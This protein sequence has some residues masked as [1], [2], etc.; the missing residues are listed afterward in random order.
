MRSRLADRFR[1]RRLTDAAAVAFRAAAIAITTVAALPFVP[2]TAADAAAAK[3]PKAAAERA[4][5]AASEAA[6]ATTLRRVAIRDGKAEVANQT[7]VVAQG[8][9]VELQWRSD[10][11]IA[12]HL[13][14][15]DI[16]TKVT[17]PATAV[18]AFT[19]RLAGRFPVT[20]HRQD[21]TTPSRGGLP[22]SP[23]LAR[24]SAPASLRPRPIHASRRP[25]RVAVLRV[26]AAGLALVAS[27]VQ[28]HG[29]GQRFDLPL[30]LWLW[31]G[32]AAATILITFVLVAVFAR[33]PAAPRRP[34]QI[35]LLAVDTVRVA[36]HPAAVALR[37]ATALLFVLVLAAGFLGTQDAYAN[38][39]VVT[40]WVVWWVGF[41]FVCALV[42]DLWEVVDPLRSIYLVGARA[43]GR[44]IG[45]T[46]LSLGRSYPTLLG[47][48]P[49]V[50]LF[51]GF[52]W[53]ELIWTSKDVPRALAGAALGYAVLGWLGMFVFGVETW[54]R[55]GDAFAI[56][57]RVLARF[58]PL[59]L[60]ST[61]PGA[62]R[63]VVL[64]PYGGGL[65]DGV[66]VAWSMVVFV[67][68]MLAT[69]TFDGFHQTPAM[70]Q[71]ETAAQTSR[72][73]AMLLFDLSQSGI[74]ETQAVH[75]AT[76]LA[77]PLAFVAAFAAT[78]AAMVVLAAR[79][80]QRV[81]ASPRIDAVGVR[82]AAGWFVMTL[83]PIAVAYHLAHYASLLL[84]AGQFVV[85]LASD[86]FGFGWDLFGTRSRAVDL[87][88]L[89]PYV[90]WYG[91]VALIVFG[92][93][94]AVLAAHAAALRL[95]GSRRT[96][97][98]S[99]LPMTALMVAYTTLS[100]WIL[101]QPIVG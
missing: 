92:H 97:L 28:A 56:A 68:L 101:A 17:P 3:V 44:A 75:T 40:V 50:L 5:G 83:V 19:A 84:T 85:P 91:S 82:E 62:P 43:L 87:G 93:V 10:R 22:R 41:A 34:W 81:R 52:A 99:Q 54:R 23:P 9:Q 48:W 36:A 77:F 76:L 35:D 26:L 63:Q 30:P 67:L 42:G 14:G 59:D 45:A 61:S 73:V 32:G 7:I 96:A 74:D 79:D 94:V 86:P 13:H 80:G 16:E 39:I 38:I 27:G 55:H 24:P 69:V 25:L 11:P 20:E 18:M 37:A 15:Y 78:C 21:G 2:A 88:V 57:F 90:A 29:F 66:P 89:D 58:A 65:L 70:Q 4:T 6:V 98:V 1:S 8:A 49:G 100:L 95:F 53:A 33:E 31:I 12:L 51:L 60:R 47:A 72:A 46:R 64:R 71:V